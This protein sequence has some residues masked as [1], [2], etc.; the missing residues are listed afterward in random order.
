VDATVVSYTLTHVWITHMQGAWDVGLFMT[1][2]E[3]DISDFEEAGEALPGGVPESQWHHHIE[4]DELCQGRP[5]NLKGQ[6]RSSPPP[7]CK[8][9]LPTGTIGQL[10]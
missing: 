4:D 2:V 9:P 7:R 10:Y 3:H 8:S 1:Q 6:S 5:K